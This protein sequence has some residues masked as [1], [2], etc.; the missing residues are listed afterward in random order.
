[1][2]RYY[3]DRR[4]ADAFLQG[5]CRFWSLAYFRDLE[6][7]GIRGDANE[8]SGLFQPVGG[9]EI[10]NQ[11]RGTQFTMPAHG[12]RSTARCDEIFVFCLSRTLSGRLWDEFGATICIEICDVPRFCVQVTKALPA[13]ARFPGRPGHEHIGH[14]VEYY[15]AS[16]AADTRWALPDRIAISKLESYAKQG[17]FRLAFSTTGALD[18]QNV[19][20]A[21]APIGSPP[22]APATDHDSRDVDLG[23][24]EPICRIHTIRPA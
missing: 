19:S 8:G 11:T 24:L 16:D 17:E 21:L 18:L 20:L 4:W 10:T 2:F 1:L 6:D 22:H 3:S 14:R 23:L 15:R 12:L 9:L 13:G 7:R 5:R